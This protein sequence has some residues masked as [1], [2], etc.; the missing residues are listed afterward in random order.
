MPD[1]RFSLDGLFKAIRD[2]LVHCEYNT[3]S[4][5]YPLS[6]FNNKAIERDS[7]TLILALMLEKV[8]DILESASL[9]SG[10][11]ST[12]NKNYVLVAINIE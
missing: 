10:N 4:G 5:T 12:I 6:D 9:L 8:S 2:Y 7:L 3:D 1:Q 11:L